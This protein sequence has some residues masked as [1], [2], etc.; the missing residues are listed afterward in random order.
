MGDLLAQFSVS[1][2][3]RHCDVLVMVQAL[4]QVAGGREVERPHDDWH[5]DPGLQDGAQSGGSSVLRSRLPRQLMSGLRLIAM[6]QI[7]ALFRIAA[8]FLYAEADM[9]SIKGINN[10]LATGL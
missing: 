4:S 9:V 7:C 5:V 8:G 10:G 2:C 6:F 3:I 1:C